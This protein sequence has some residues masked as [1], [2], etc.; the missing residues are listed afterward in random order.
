MKNEEVQS[1]KMHEAQTDRTAGKIDK[2][3]PQ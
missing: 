3:I 2:P 1:F